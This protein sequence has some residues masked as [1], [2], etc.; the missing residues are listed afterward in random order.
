[1][2]PMEEE[3]KHVRDYLEIEKA[4]FEDKLEVTYDLPETMDIRIP[5]LILQPIV[6][7]AVRYGIGRDGKRKVH[8]AAERD[9]GGI[10]VTVR[11][12]GKGF[13]E[14]I[15]EKLERGEPVG[16]SIGL[17][18]VD[19]R[20]KR[21]YGED[22]GIQISSTDEGSCVR[23]WFLKECRKETKEGEICGNDKDSSC[24]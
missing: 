12:Q 8:I 1:M 20:M 10:I 17:R 18:N 14:E 16:G 24:R 22:H 11:D 9:P 23:L 15:L 2:V 7:N 21:T 6:E 13:Q 3:L 4:R 5:T 19:Q